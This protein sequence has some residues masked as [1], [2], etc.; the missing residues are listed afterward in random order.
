MEQ[1]NNAYFQEIRNNFSITVF[2]NLLK[3]YFL[4]TTLED[5]NESLLHKFEQLKLC[6]ISFL[7]EYE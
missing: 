3:L 1:E 2:I 6:N 4:G 7:Q 5:G